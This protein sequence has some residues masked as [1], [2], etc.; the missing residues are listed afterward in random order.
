MSPWTLTL[1]LTYVL[2]LLCAIHEYFL[3]TCHVQT[4]CSVWGVAS[5]HRAPVHAARNLTA[6]SSSSG[7]YSGLH[8]HV[9]SCT[10]HGTK[11]SDSLF[12]IICSLAM[13][14]TTEPNITNKPSAFP[15]ASE[16]NTKWCACYCLFVFVLA[17]M[18]ALANKGSCPN[19]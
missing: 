8:A 9:T 1:N 18:L 10:S 2:C 17:G 4:F 14:A 6:V 19:H 3:G 5:R 15:V 7:W 13:A 11:G 12:A 16:T